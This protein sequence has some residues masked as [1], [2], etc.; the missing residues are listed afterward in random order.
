MIPYKEKDRLSKV[1]E[2]IRLIKN[3]S[4]ELKLIIYQSKTELNLDCDVHEVKLK[5]KANLM[6]R[7]ISPEY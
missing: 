4:E 3:I 5:Y 1:I 7:V 2:H 6:V